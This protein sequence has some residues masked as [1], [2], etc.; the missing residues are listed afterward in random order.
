IR[1]F[2]RLE[3]V[4]RKTQVRGSKLRIRRL[5]SDNRNLGFWRQ[6]VPDGVHSGAD[7]GKRFIRVVIEL[8]SR[9]DRR[10]AL[11]ALGLDIIDSIRSRDGSFDRRGDKATH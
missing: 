5:N 10:K 6:V 1:N 4:R 3:N 7:I 11:S 8:Q 9:G 2:V